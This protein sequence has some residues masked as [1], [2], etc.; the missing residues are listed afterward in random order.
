MA[1]PHPTRPWAPGDPDREYQELLQDQAGREGLSVE[2]FTARR[3]ELYGGLFDAAR[4]R[5]ERLGLSVEALYDHDRALI[6]QSS[7]PR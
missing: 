5:A 3:R 6:E 1:K 2:Q 7:Y 4:A